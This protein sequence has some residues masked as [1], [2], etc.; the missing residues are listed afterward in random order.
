MEKITGGDRT[1]SRPNLSAPAPAYAAEFHHKFYD[2]LGEGM[3]I[4]LKELG[5]GFAPVEIREEQKLDVVRDG[6]ETYL[7]L[8]LGDTTLKIRYDLRAG[9]PYAYEPEFPG[10]ECLVKV[11]EAGRRRSGT[12]IDS[13]PPR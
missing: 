10:Q 4:E 1:A 7:F 12:G 11:P 13:D 6:D 3:R 9:Q 2:H 5:R 8:T